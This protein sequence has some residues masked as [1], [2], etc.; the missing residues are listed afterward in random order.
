MAGLSGLPIASQSDKFIKKYCIISEK[1]QDLIKNDKE[2]NKIILK[3]EDAFNYYKLEYIERESIANNYKM[4]KYFYKK[5]LIE[6]T[7]DKEILGEFINN[8][9]YNEL[10]L[11]SILKRF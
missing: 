6:K 7:N 1:L 4:I 2:L 10:L 9:W 11:N 5:Y 3:I 8:N